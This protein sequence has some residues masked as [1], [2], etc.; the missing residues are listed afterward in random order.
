MWAESLETREGV[1]SFKQDEH[2]PCSHHCQ[3][4]TTPG[5]GRCSWPGCPAASLRTV[6]QA[7]RQ[8]VRRLL[9]STHCLCEREE[10]GCVPHATSH[11]RLGF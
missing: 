4:Q 11:A 2:W 6:Q 1:G 5:P 3:S 10:A 9:D 8:S 7:E